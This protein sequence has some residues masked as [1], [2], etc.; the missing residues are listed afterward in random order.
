MRCPCACGGCGGGL[1]L[2]LFGKREPIFW[3]E[4]DAPHVAW[5]FQFQGDLEELPDGARALNPSN[6]AARGTWGL[7]CL[8]MGDLE[9]DPHV[10]QHV[11]FGLIAAAV[12]V[13]NESGGPLSERPT[14][15]V[16]SRNRQRNRLNNARAS[17]L[18]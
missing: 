6:A 9:G 3:R 17:A 13:D 1:R 15:G 16:D 18:P 8:R 14:E 11:V 7:A 2:F 5:H 12:A 10:F 4:G